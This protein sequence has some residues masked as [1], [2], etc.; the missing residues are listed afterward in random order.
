MMTANPLPPVMSLISG[1]VLHQKHS[2]S[3]CCCEKLEMT[4]GDDSICQRDLMT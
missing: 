3:G 4:A 2:H 1:P